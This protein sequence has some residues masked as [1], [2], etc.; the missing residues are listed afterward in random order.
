VKF[1][2]NGG[3]RMETSEKDV[4]AFIAKVKEVL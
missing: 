2:S 3:D 4:D 1:D